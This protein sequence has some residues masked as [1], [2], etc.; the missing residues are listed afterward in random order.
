MQLIPTDR[1]EN[2]W[3]TG[4]ENVDFSSRI[5]SFSGLPQSRASAARRAILAVPGTSRPL[6]TNARFAFVRMS[7][8]AVSVPAGTRARRV[9]CGGERCQPRDFG[10]LPR[11]Q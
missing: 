2:L 11:Q 8:F 4:P 5:E 9:V 1:V 3:K 10:G 7:A 6:R